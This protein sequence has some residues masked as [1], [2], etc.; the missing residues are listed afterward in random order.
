MCQM[1]NYGGG[2]NI[3]IVTEVTSA[4]A[5]RITRSFVNKKYMLETF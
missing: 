4:F 5:D 1:F 2:S 3:L